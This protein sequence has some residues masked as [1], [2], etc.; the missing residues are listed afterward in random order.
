MTGPEPLGVLLWRSGEDGYSHPGTCLGSHV[1]ALLQ[2]KVPSHAD[3]A[4]PAPHKGAYYI[5]SLSWKPE[6]ALVQRKWR[7]K[8]HLRLHPRFLL[9][10]VLG[11]PNWSQRMYLSMDLCLPHPSL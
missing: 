8:A 1:S 9:A 3:P 10:A 6:S 11:A 2:Q 5:P 4:I 7:A